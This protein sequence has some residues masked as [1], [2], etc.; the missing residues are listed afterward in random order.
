MPSFASSDSSDDSEADDYILKI[1][2]D[3]P[4][5]PN[6]K[7][8]RATTLNF[9]QEKNLIRENL[10]IAACLLHMSGNGQDASIRVLTRSHKTQQSSSKERWVYVQI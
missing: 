6:P 10:D 5:Q 2:L 8:Q 3:T 4:L 1:D 7:P 9:H